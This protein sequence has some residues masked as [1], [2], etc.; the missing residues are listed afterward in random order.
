[1]EINAKRLQFL[2][3]LVYT[4]VSVSLA[5][6]L[7]LFSNRLIRDLDSAVEPPLRSS[8]ED[9]VAA[10][11]LNREG[12]ELEAELATAN[13]ELGRL[14]KGLE[15]ARDQSRYE[16]ESFDTWV[17]TRKT[18]GNRENDPQV[19]AR[20]RRLDTLALAE[21]DWKKRV[22]KQEEMLDGLVQKSTAIQN[23][24]GQLEEQTQKRY[25]AAV[26]RY[27]LHVFLVRLL[28]VGPVLA[29]GIFLFV[30][31][32]SHRFWPLFMGFV[33]FSLYAFF[34]GLIPYLPSY[35]GYVRN[36]VG[37]VMSLGLG[38]YSIRTI[39]NYVDRKRAELQT[40]S[41]ERARKVSLTVAE[42]ALEKHFCPSCGKDF[43]KMNWEN[44]GSSKAASFCR[45]CGLGL[46][47]PCTRC[48]SP[49]FL[50]LPYCTECG[51]DHSAGSTTA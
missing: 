3:R 32:R 5:I 51:L 9:P 34:F 43:L 29:L 31:Y 27:E 14:N 42:K 16:K 39:R 18:I 1:M 33:W 41:T 25:S 15:S 45:H 7:I 22:S 37:V 21:Q 24:R 17:Q 35:G 38:F 2:S 4:L 46:F 8:F 40:S 49:V 13:E 30:R 48:S 23:R 12:K 20:A 11:A 28:F 19:L 10:K 44:P 6:F 50:H 26:S 36:G 47:A